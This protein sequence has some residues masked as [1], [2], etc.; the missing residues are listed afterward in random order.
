M[1][2]WTTG[3]LE[4][5]GGAEELEIASRRPDGSLREYTP[6]WVVR[7]GSELVVRSVRG[8][9]GHWYTHAV[10]NRRGRIRAGGVERDVAFEEPQ[11]V[12]PQA[13]DDAYRT[14]YARYAGGVLEPLFT[15]DAVAAELRLVPA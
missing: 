9:A 7:I 4:A 3:Q 15:P 6:I 8:Q 5:I 12:D 13:I 10:E 14:K 2:E 1:T 11:G